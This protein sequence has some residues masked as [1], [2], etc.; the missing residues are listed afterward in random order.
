[1]GISRQAVEQIE[2]RALLKLRIGLGLVQVEKIPS[3]GVKPRL[4][5]H[6]TPTPEAQ[7][8][9]EAFEDLMADREECQPT[10][11]ATFDSH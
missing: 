5:Y 11:Y 8:L 9:R 2:N 1:M 10:E 7:E 4:R 6:H 3:R